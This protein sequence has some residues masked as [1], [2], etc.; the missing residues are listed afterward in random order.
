MKTKD[1]LLAIEE[2][3]NVGIA[4]EITIQALKEAFESTIKKKNYEDA[5]VSV[6]ISPEKGAID[7]YSIRSI[8][9]EVEDDVLQV[10]R[11]DA[12]EEL[13]SIPGT[14]VDGDNRLNT[15][16]LVDD[17]TRADALKFKSILKQKIKE[18]EKANIYAAYSDKVGEIVTGYVEKVEPRYTL[19]NLGR[20]SVILSDK[21]KIGDETFKTGD[22]VKVYLAEVNS[23]S[24]GPQ[25]A[26]SRADAGFLKRL[27]EEEI[28]DVFDGT[29]VIK[30]IAR[31]AGER[32]KVSVISN[33]INVD[34]VGACIG[35][36]GQKIQR[37]CSQINREKI[38][39]IQYHIHPGLFIAEALK[40][41][42][43]VGVKIVSDEERKAIAVVKEGDLRVSIGKR[44][45]N[46]R[47][48]VK[49]TNY[50]I[51]IIELPEAL[52]KGIDFDTIEKM[53]DR[54][55]QMVFEAKRAQILAEQARDEALRAAAAEE[56]EVVA[57]EETLV[58]E[59][60]SPIEEVATPVVEDTSVVEEVAAPVV[61]E[62]P[63][64]ETAPVV[65]EKV[66]EE[67]VVEYKPKIVGKRISLDELEKSIEQEK[68]KST[69]KFV[70]RKPKKEEVEEKP[71]EEKKVIDTSKNM[72]IYTD[73]ELEELENEDYEDDYYDDDEEI[74]YTEYDK[75]YEE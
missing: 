31:E 8:V 68:K 20:T 62:T 72:A 24:Q 54:E 43:V 60:A 17:F 16:I 14:F 40:P 34:P 29:V 30:D 25:I 10:S 59:D 53:K 73:E 18:A 6:E 48:A 47:L 28:H 33:D 50:H 26:V 13:R 21:H 51:D 1:F 58:V 11:E 56:E 71:V 39:I 69:P 49:L 41:A 36:G 5:M 46:A 66:V 64:V 23:S 19:I 4:R 52:E 27:F 9:D 22:A 38:D 37:I 12:E 42:T 35:Q 2:L 70:A 3:E 55:E 74:D 45:V 61:E 15:P 65:E 7:I 67:E 57:E 75:Y 63:V 32:S 44:G